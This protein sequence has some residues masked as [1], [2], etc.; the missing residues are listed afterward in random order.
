MEFKQQEDWVPVPRRLQGGTLLQQ[1][2]HSHRRPL[3]IRARLAGPAPGVGGQDMQ[4]RDPQGAEG[5]PGGTQHLDLERPLK[6]TR[7]KVTWLK[8]AQ[9]GTG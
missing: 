2:H 4:F 9:W 7:P 3:R 8:V 1:S 6:V 5:R